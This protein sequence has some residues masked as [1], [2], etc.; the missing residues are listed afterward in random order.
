LLGPFYASCFSAGRLIAGVV[1]V[2]DLVCDVEVSGMVEEL[3][4]LSAHYGLVLF[5]GHILCPPLSTAFPSGLA[6]SSRMTADKEVV[7]DLAGAQ[8]QT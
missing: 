8:Q 3:L 2:D 7:N 5:C 6:T 4:H 1:R